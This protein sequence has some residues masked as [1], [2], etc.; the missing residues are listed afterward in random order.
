MNSLE[1]GRHMRLWAAVI[2]QAV[3]DIEEGHKIKY[4]ILKAKKA[5]EELPRMKYTPEEIADF[6]NGAERWFDSENKGAGSFNWIC[7]MCDLD[8]DRIRNMTKTL[9][10]RT[11]LIKASKRLSKNREEELRELQE[12][13]NDNNSTGESKEVL[14]LRE[15]ERSKNRKDKNRK[16]STRSNKSKDV[17]TVRTEATADGDHKRRQKRK[18]SKGSIGVQQ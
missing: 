7:E 13:E 8:A 6:T 16:R 12:E 1:Y 17:R 4:M 2:L 14:L 11:R 5:G 15:P 9:E 3:Y 10:G 18:P